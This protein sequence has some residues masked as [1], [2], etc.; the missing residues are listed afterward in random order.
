MT[1]AEPTRPNARH[2]YDGILKRD[3]RRRAAVHPTEIR[4]RSSADLFVLA[5]SKLNLCVRGEATNS[6]ENRM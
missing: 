4:I 2:E 1:S 3:T 6:E 5:K